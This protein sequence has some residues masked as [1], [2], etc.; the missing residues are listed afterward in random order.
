MKTKMR[1]S[2]LAAAILVT[3]PIGAVAEGYWEHGA[4]SVLPNQSVAAAAAFHRYM[5]EA[6]TLDGRFSDGKAVAEGV[7]RG[8]AYDP[9]QMQEGMVLYA[10]YVALRNEQFVASVRDLDTR[11]GRSAALQTLTA[12]PA[13]AASLPGGR[14]AAT[15]V[16]A[17][18]KS[19]GEA[20]RAS[21]QSVK[22]AA[23]DLQHQ[24][25][26][27]AFVPNPQGRLAE[28]KALGAAARPSDDDA[29]RLATVSA[30]YGRVK[31][32]ETSAPPAG[33]VARRG[34]ALAALLA[35]GEPVDGSQAKGLL[36]EARSATCLR[37]AKLNFHQ[38]LSVAGPQY[39]DVYCLG[40]H[41][42]ID[43]G[44]CVAAAASGT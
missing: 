36:K 4:V 9:V 19:E 26:S 8:A 38:C 33:A 35:L 34:L 31:A 23:Y 20:L 42:L 29:P 43:T 3:T 15:E 5:Q 12:D 1:M 11:L 16:A 30:A 40:Q 10:A 28:A 14:E 24:P 7:K 37:M 44:Q 18:L 13:V 2:L 39:E 32:G 27:L 17:A 25:W 41:A 22:K 6:A 21:G